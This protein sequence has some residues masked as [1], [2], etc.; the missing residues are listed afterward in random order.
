MP[1]HVDNL[2]IASNSK[3][4]LSKVKTE[5]ATHFKIHNQG[6]TKLIL[7]MN[8]QWDQQVHT[9]SLSQP[10]YIESI[11]DQ[12]G[13]TECNPALMPM[14]KGQKLSAQMSPD[15]PEGKLEMRKY[16]Y[17]ELVGKLLYLAIATWPNITY[18]VRVLCCFIENL[19]IEHWNTA[20]RV[21]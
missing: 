7:S 8:I 1:I 3:G 13:M 10:G 4:A 17:C 6:L 18:V 2:L 15:T 16:P 20:K 21:L 19:G 14:D 11:L 12:F 5:L 9:I